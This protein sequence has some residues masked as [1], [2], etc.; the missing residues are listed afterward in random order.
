MAVVEGRD[1]RCFERIAN[2]PG[3]I[4]HDGESPVG[5]GGALLR[6]REGGDALF[7]ARDDVPEV[8]DQVVSRLEP[9]QVRRESVAALP[10]EL[11]RRRRP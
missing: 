9:A 3:R 6:L 10:V 2:G 8:D 4:D 7:V 11:T 5:F 1:R